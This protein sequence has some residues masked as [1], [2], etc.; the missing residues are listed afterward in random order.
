[1]RDAQCNKKLRSL[2]LIWSLPIFFHSQTNLCYSANGAFRSGILADVGIQIDD[3]GSFRMA[4][5]QLEFGTSV[6]E[7]LRG[8]GKSDQPSGKF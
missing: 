2:E 3:Q 1:M 8:P 5:R 7:V 6:E 4:L